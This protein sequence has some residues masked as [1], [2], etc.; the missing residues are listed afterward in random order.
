MDI[1]L[2]SRRYG[3]GQPII[4]LH[5]NGEDSTYFKHQIEALAAVR[6]VITIDSRAHGQS[7]RGNMPMSI[8]QLADDLYNFMMDEQIE[9]ADILGF[10]DGGNIALAFTLKHQEMVNRLILNG[11]NL[12]ARGVKPKYQISV[13]ISFTVARILAIFIKSYKRRAEI[14]GLMVNEPNI[15]STALRTIQNKTLVIVGTD[16]MICHGHSLLIAK[17][18]PNAKFVQIEGDHFIAY[19]KPDDFN[20]AVL[21]FLSE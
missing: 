1:K 20:K 15:L 5:G 17:S 18:L 19:R 9:Q 12:N 21:E 4:M 11:A 7:P 16:D 14:L 2:H 3:H 10:S 6:E 13:V 8:Q